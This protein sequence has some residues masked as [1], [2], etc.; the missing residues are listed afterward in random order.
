MTA[1]RIKRVKTGAD[2]TVPPRE[3]LLDSVSVVVENTSSR[4]AT[5]NHAGIEDMFSGNTDSFG[6]HAFCIEFPHR[7]TSGHQIEFS[8]SG[9]DFFVFLGDNADGLSEES[10]FVVFV[11]K[12]AFFA[13]GSSVQ[14][15]GS[16][17]ATAT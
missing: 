5:I 1:T 15:P 3:R 6:L 12:L 2:R 8:V 9:S 13:S 10:Q 4:D 7:L 14:Q 17:R 16:D 11:A